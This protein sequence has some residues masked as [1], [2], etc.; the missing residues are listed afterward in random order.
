MKKPL[1][2]SLSAFVMAAIFLALL[3]GFAL[4]DMSANHYMPGRF[5]PMFEITHIGETGVQFSFMGFSYDWSLSVFDYLAEDV[6]YLRGVFSGR[7]SLARE[8]AVL[9]WESVESVDIL[10]YLS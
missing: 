8:A 2:Y 5:T 6:Y 7:G 3:A 4:V 1:Y 10:G 9:L